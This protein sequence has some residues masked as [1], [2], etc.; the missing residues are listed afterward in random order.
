MPSCSDVWTQC[1][2]PEDILRQRAANKCYFFPV[3]YTEGSCRLENPH[4]SGTSAYGGIRSSYGHARCP[5]VKTAGE[6][7]SSNFTSTEIEEVRR[8][9][10]CS[11]VVGGDYI[12]RSRNQVGRC[13]RGI[14]CCIDFADNLGG[15]GYIDDNKFRSLLIYF[16]KKACLLTKYTA[17]V[18]D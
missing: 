16:L 10:W 8:G 6:S 2:L 14:V 4:I 11:I 9:A 3:C 17:G 1:N 15:S 18:Q 5:L 7:E 13:R 12:I